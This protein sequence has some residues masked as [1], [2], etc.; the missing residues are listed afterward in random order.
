M[1]RKN[2]GSCYFY[3]FILLAGRRRKLLLLWERSD[4]SNGPG[5]FRRVWNACGWT[6]LRAPRSLGNLGPEGRAGIINTA[7]NF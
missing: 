1:A 2:A 3:F 5:K 7:I 6:R 4:W